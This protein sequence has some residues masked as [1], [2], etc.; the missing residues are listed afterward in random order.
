MDGYVDCTVN[1]HGIASAEGGGGDPVSVALPERALG[2]VARSGDRQLDVDS[3]TGDLLRESRRAL[4]GGDLVLMVPPP[5]A[6]G[7]LGWTAPAGRV[8][9]VLTRRLDDLHRRGLLDRHL[10]RLL[11]SRYGLDGYPGGAAE[12]RQ[13][14]GLGRQATTNAV[15]QA[16]QILAADIAEQPVLPIPRPTLGDARREELVGT[17]LSTLHGPQG[18]HRLRRYVHWRVR[19]ELLGHELDSRST[20][21]AAE[22]QRWNRTA[23]E[24]LAIAADHLDRDRLPWSAYPT[25]EAS[26]MAELDH[27]KL[28]EEGR[29]TALSVGAL[30]ALTRTGIA[31]AWA[32]ARVKPLAVVGMLADGYRPLI[33]LAQVAEWAQRDEDGLPSDPSDYGPP[34]P[35][36]TTVRMQVL[37]QVAQ[38]VALRGYH[39]LAIAYAGAASRLAASVGPP[40]VPAGAFARFQTGLA[41]E[42]ISYLRGPAALDDTRSWQQ[43]LRA[44]L[45]RYGVH[46]P[47]QPFSLAQAIV[48]AEH[49]AALTGRASGS[50]VQELLAPIREILDAS[51]EGNYAENRRRLEIVSRRLA[52]VLGDKEAARPDLRDDYEP[53]AKWESPST[54]Y[55]EWYCAAPTATALWDRKRIAT[56]S[57]DE[58]RR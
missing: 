46:N 30:R 57:T 33:E 55:D 50:S 24:W 10:V 20:P 16:M 37:L 23:R 1:G 35:D 9:E 56:E 26:D 5:L 18:E 19:R 15:N 12:A 17:V 31:A 28:Q 4:K 27:W 43:R 58:W 45:E 32:D 8:R 21:G 54:Q 2:A 51:A 53:G 34:M 36:G 7:R 11:A 42:S 49:A 48:R 40:S 3:S 47:M 6:G 14:H 41:Y 29:R 52:V 13:L 38:V 22:R 39:H 44:D 25:V